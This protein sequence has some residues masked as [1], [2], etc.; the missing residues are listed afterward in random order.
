MVQWLARACHAKA[1]H[2]A[3]AEASAVACSH[4]SHA[5]DSQPARAEASAVAG[6]SGGAAA[7]LPITDAGDKHKYKLFEEEDR[8]SHVG[9]TC[10]NSQ[11]YGQTYGV[12]LRCIVSTDVW[13]N[14][15]INGFKQA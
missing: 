7:S 15:V 1:R 9:H 5:R 8:C 10:R 6:P 11:L 2:P 14:L 13:A 3:Q 12:D 4:V